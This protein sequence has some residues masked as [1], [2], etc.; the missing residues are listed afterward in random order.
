MQ[1]VQDRYLL[2]FSSQHSLNAFAGI[3]P[4]MPPEDIHLSVNEVASAF[5]NIHTY[6]FPTHLNRGKP[7]FVEDVAR[8]LRRIENPVRGA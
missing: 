1:Q 4:I 3:L 5:D 2:N 8:V 7:N 6:Y